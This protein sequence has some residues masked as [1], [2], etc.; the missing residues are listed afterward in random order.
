MKRGFILT[1]I[2]LTIISVIIFA[3]MINNGFHLSGFT[4]YESQP[5]AASGK[6]TYIKENF[7]NTNYGTDPKIL[8]GTDSLGRNLRGLIE[9]DLSSI[10]SS[11]VLSA[12]LQVNLSY[13]S[14]DSNITIKIYRLTSS[15]TE[16]KTTWT[17]SSPSQLW[18]TVGGDYSEEVT[19]LQFSNV[20][21]LYNFTI[22]NLVRGWINGS[23]S[24]YGLMLVSNDSAVEDIK[25]IDSSDS[26]SASARPKIT[27][28]YVENAPLSIIN[29]SNNSNITNLKQTSGRGTGAAVQ[30]IANLTLTFDKTIY[31]S[32][33][34]E[35]TV[36][37]QISNNGGKD[38]TGL[39]LELENLDRLY[40]TVSPALIT[41]LKK[42]E[43]KT[44]EINF[45][46]TEFLEEENFN[47]SIKTSEIEVKEPV[48]IIVLNFLSYLQEEINR[49]TNRIESVRSKL[50][51]DRLKEEIKKCENI[52]DE[53]KSQI[54]EEEFI[55]ARDNIQNADDCIDNVEKQISPFGWFPKLNFPAL[56]TGDIFWI[57]TSAVLIMMIFII[58][59]LIKK[60]NTAS[61]IS[62]FMKSNEEKE[63][64]PVTM[65]QKYFDDKL[66]QIREKL[67]S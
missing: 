16:S 45:L 17:N 2:Q 67:G 8:V 18:S 27:I 1:L 29:A 13:S 25:E 48:K 34:I 22:T 10:P 47:C 15:W 56:N 3:L 32:K 61:K 38:L 53:I 31:L 24:N 46:I 20:S 54:S 65:N 11:T 51:S 55:N 9:F 33:D 5:D 36:S 49:L 44:F 58:I 7:N 52:T 39:Y 66:K 59:F 43:T 30:E 57:S 12:N 23:Y 26:D 50:T 41:S 40:Y 42:A 35:K 37:V 60:V 21:G 14:S 4:I 28:N 63:S 64:A 19:S 62:S 6:D